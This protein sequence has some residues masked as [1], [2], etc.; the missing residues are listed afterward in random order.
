MTSIISTDKKKCV[1]F[2]SKTIFYTK[3]LSPIDENKYW[4]TNYEVYTARIERSLEMFW[5]TGTK[6]IKWNINNREWD[7]YLEKCIIVD[8]TLQN[9][10]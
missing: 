2:G 7:S 9:E 8:H 4:Q 10:Y 5:T 6:G 3:H 1:S